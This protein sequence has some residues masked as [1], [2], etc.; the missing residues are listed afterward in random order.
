MCEMKAL[1]FET[2]LSE[3]VL[4]NSLFLCFR[5]LISD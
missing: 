3:S 5:R 4:S 1:I 2:F